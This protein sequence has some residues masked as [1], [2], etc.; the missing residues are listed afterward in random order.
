MSL[1]DW[2]RPRFLD[3]AMRQLDELRAPTVG[4]AHGDVLEIGFGTW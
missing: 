2:I 3:L 4:L 1:G